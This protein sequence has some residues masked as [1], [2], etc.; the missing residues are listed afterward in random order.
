MNFLSTIVLVSVRLNELLPAKSTPYNL[1]E[2]TII[3]KQTE[4][5]TVPTEINTITILVEITADN[6]LL[7]TQNSSEFVESQNVDRC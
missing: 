2:T 6:L 4:A 7:V 5:M 1:N 3:F